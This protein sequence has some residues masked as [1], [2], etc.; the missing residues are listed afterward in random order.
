MKVYPALD[1]ADQPVVIASSV[2]REVATEL[3]ERL[4]PET[5]AA[6]L[7]RILLTAYA[8]VIAQLVA[9]GDVDLGEARNGV[10]EDFA[11]VDLSLREL[12]RRQAAQGTL[13]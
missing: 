9:D 1:P 7:V 3:A 2:I 4:T 13:Q 10:R 6:T 5:A 8:S 11:A 12:V